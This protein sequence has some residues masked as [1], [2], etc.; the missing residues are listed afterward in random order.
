MLEVLPSCKHNLCVCTAVPQAQSAGNTADVCMSC[1]QPDGVLGIDGGAAHA[2][3][4][5]C[6]RRLL[7]LEEAWWDIPS[8][9]NTLLCHTRSNMPCVLS[10]RVPCLRCFAGVTTSADDSE[11]K[12]VHMLYRERHPGKQGAKTAAG[13]VFGRR[14]EAAAQDAA[15]GVT[16]AQPISAVATDTG[17]AAAEPKADEFR[18]DA[19]DQVH[20]SLPYMFASAT[21]RQDYITR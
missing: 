8:S 1:R 12:S 6:V 17:G 14:S 21:K 9:R 13:Q 15:A 3:P 2:P 11:E 20:R 19:S 4:A 5:V 18:S 7:R 10:P 16:A